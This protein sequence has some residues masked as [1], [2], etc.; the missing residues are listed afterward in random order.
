MRVLDSSDP[1]E[2]SDEVLERP[3]PLD[4]THPFVYGSIHRLTCEPKERV[5][6][7]PIGHLGVLMERSGKD[8]PVAKPETH[9]AN[10]RSTQVFDPHQSNAVIKRINA[11]EVRGRTVRVHHPGH[12]HPRPPCRSALIPVAATVSFG[13][14]VRC[15]TAAPCGRAGNGRLEGCAVRVVAPSRSP[16]PRTVSSDTPAKGRSMG[17]WVDG[18]MGGRGGRGCAFTEGPCGEWSG[19][20]GCQSSSSP[21][22]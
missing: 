22:F 21:S 8:V 17:R 2:K 10:V 12:M 3:P 9:I 18:S 16:T 4:Y 14:V 6:G 11:D 1:R 5:D 15:V 19:L 20:V 13:V 7:V